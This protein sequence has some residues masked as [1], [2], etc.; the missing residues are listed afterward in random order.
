MTMAVDDSARHEPMITDAAGVLPAS[1]AMPAITALA[2]TTCRP[3]RPKTRR[4]MVT[5][6]W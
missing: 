1:A 5:R 6:R 3:P 4:R 2:I